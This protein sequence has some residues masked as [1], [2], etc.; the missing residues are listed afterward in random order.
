MII[1]V[2]NNIE[3]RTLTLDNAEEVFSVVDHNRIYLRKWLPWVDGTDKVS[4]VEKVI[5]SWEK[6]R[7]S[8][9]D[10]NGSA[11]YWKEFL[12]TANVFT[13]NIPI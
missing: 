11:L 12:E 1:T 10:L 2:R 4:V 3:M 6:E 13:T 9:T 5:S 7:E 8:G